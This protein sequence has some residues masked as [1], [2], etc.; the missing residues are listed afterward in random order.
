MTSL[1][2]DEAFLEHFQ[3]DHDPFAARVPG[4]KFFPAQRKSVLGQLHHLARYSQL[5]LTVVGP[6]GAGKT[7]LRQALVASA[8]KQTVQCVVLSGKD[9]NSLRAQFAQ[10][11][12]SRGSDLAATQAQVVQ[13]ALTGQ[14]VYLLVDDAEQ[15]ADEALETLL[16]IAAGSAE[17]RPHV[18]LFG[19]PSLV[20]R[21]EF[22]CEGEE[23]I[24]V[25]ELQ[26]YAE[27]ET[28]EYLEQRLQGAGRDI[29]VF[30]DG[31]LSVIHEH[32]G[33]WPGLI[34]GV[35]RDVLIEGMLAERQGS[36]TA[37]LAWRMPRRHML[38]IAVVALAV[39]AAW[40]MQGRPD[41]E[42]PSPR[43][44]ALDMSGTSRAPAPVQESLPAAAQSGAQEQQ[45]PG[46]PQ[47]ILRQPLAEAA[48]E[49]SELEGFS[50]PAQGA[51]PP[52]PQAEPSTAISA[53]PIPPV[54][55][56]PVVRSAPQ[57]LPAER[58]APAP[59]AAPAPV[60]RP[61]PAPAPAPVKARQTAASGGASAS[62]YRSQPAGHYALQILGT[63]SEQSAKALVAQYG[64]GYRYF[65]KSH[66]GR[67][68]YVVTYGSFASRSAAQA[69]LAT[70]PARL[71]AEKPWPK[72]FASIRQ[73]SAL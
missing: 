70:L 72:T 22:L 7:L 16:V 60:P 46:E 51:A 66:Q 29:S 19:E 73:E 20:P 17:A 5:L 6:S 44:A 35:A 59:D 58:A 14:E 65:S 67:P 55:V 49:E 42:P 3:L 63:R 33:G 52:L 9:A 61:A 36:R 24:H 11:I 69:A 50:P 56:P 62:W 41:A 57:A 37:G 71:R 45:L 10:G 54:I 38:A 40:F 32:S 68:L 23:R 53:T 47:P 13:L 39:V 34:N 43:T 64:A 25:I 30:S 26:P 8:N 2:A 27:E 48:G 12:G 21:L 4:F 18:F 28:R 31:Q 15:L 1:Q